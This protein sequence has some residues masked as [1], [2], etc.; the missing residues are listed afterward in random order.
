MLPADHLITEVAAFVEAVNKAIP[1]AQQGRL[2]RQLLTESMV[3][4]GIAT[5]LGVLLAL[6]LQDLILGFASLELLGLQDIGISGKMMTFAMV[7]SLATALLFGIAP[8][9]LASSAW[10]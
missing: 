8:S 3:T 7:L 5:G 4:A 2:V 6:W 1:L 9:A 10:D